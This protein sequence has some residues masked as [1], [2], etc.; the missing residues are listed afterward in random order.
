MLQHSNEVEFLALETQNGV[1]SKGKKAELE[2][3]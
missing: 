3:G 1:L 2:R